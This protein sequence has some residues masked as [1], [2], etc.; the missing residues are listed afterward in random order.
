MTAQ[1]RPEF[2]GRFGSLEGSRAFGQTFFTWYNQEHH[3]SGIAMLTPEILHYGMAAEVI[4]QRQQALDAAYVSNPER[5]THARPMHPP[6]PTAAW[7]NPSTPTI[8]TEENSDASCLK[9]VDIH[10]EA[11]LLLEYR[12]VG[13]AKLTLTE[14]AV[15]GSR[16]RRRG[17]ERAISVART[18]LTLLPV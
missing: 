2:P 15:L 12:S 16:S 6:Q 1:D 13:A 14:G 17:G 10:H 5:F 4:G 3:H 18:R 9:V 11:P 7:I 8:A